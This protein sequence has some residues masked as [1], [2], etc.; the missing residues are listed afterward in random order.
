MKKYI[1]EALG[2][3]V[4]TLVVA[5]S[6]TGS[7]AVPT[8]VLAVVTVGLF[9]Y[10][11]GHISGSHINPAVT[12]GLWSINK[13]EKKE[14]L[15][16]IGAQFLGALI[17]L[18]IFLLSGDRKIDITLGNSLVAGFAEFLGMAFYG[19]FI[20]AVV[21]GKTPAYL[22]GLMI[23]FALL[24]GI[25]VASLLGSEGIINPA[26]SLGFGSFSLMYLLAPLA[27][28]ALGMHAYKYLASE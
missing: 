17:A 5:L 21:Y 4:L 26:V 3:L 28:S 20:A 2:T 14:A 11:V 12:F 24:I 25:S 16:Y 18:G 6:L 19:F 22:S 8:P 15:R 1:A 7:F 23:G 9:V 27:G 10:A 13:I